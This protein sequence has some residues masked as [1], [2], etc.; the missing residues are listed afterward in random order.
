[1]R[2]VR[3]EEYF[4]Q[5]RFGQAY[6][7]SLPVTVLHSELEP[8]RKATSPLDGFSAFTAAALF[9][10]LVFATVTV[11][12]RQAWALQWFQIGIYGLVIIWVLSGIRRAREDDTGGVCS[13]L[14]YLIPL[15]GVFQIVA[16]T[17]SSSFDTREETL[18]WGALSGVFYL[19]QAVNQSESSRRR[20]LNATLCFATAMAVL[21]LLQLNTSNGHILWYF[22]TEYN[23]IFATFQNK[24]NFV[25]FIEIAL[26]IALWGAVSEGWRSWWYALA[27]G[28]L[29]AS[30]IGA[31]SR[32]GFLLC[33]AELIA[34]PMIGMVKSRRS[35][36]KISLRAA[37]S[38]AL[39]VPV[40]AAVFTLAV[41]W[42]RVW[43]RFQ[44]KDPFAIRREFFLGA[45]DMAWKRPLTGFGLGTFEQVYQRY[46]SK[47][48]PFYANHAHN[49]WAEFA[50]DGGVPF[51]LL[52]AIPFVAAVPKAFRHPWGLGVVATML[53]ACVD[54]P[55]P[56]PAVSGW[57]F[58]FL[59]MLYVTRRSERKA[60]VTAK[61]AGISGA[62]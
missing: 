59:A 20:F 14:V 17:T 13:L 19:S 31:A 3:T 37:T 25:Q 38:V 60:Q 11:W 6:N 39:L 9:L 7:G 56:R 15:W 42:Q 12:V 62:A 35:E 30:A 33:T 32:A 53:N 2:S 52:V 34:I 43:A 1:L 51:L 16:H 49:D 8:V 61:Q 55:F 41:G 45:A 40:I 10:L 50:A 44:E 4:S 21:C 22:P 58:A 28:V 5:F 23:E 48:F 18:R 36:A 54:F 26:P 29:Y 24:N 27:G 47:D 46:S 57:M